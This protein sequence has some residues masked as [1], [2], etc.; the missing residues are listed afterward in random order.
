MKHLLFLKVFVEKD[1]TLFENDNEINTVIW[2]WVNEV[3]SGIKIS[4]KGTNL[5][6]DLYLNV[7]PM[8]FQFKGDLTPYFA[9]L[10]VCGQIFNNRNAQ[11]MS[12]VDLMKPHQN[13]L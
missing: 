9:K 4:S 11:S 13:W 3:W 12:L 7:K 5:S 6:K 1:S 2:T 10:P 8:P